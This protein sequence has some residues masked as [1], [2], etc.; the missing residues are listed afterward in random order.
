MDNIKNILFI[1]FEGKFNENNFPNIYNKITFSNINDIYHDT[2]ADILVINTNNL[3][4]NE[5]DIIKLEN[6]PVIL[7]DNYSYI[8]KFI[9]IR[10]NQDFYFIYQDTQ[11]K[12]LDTLEFFINK[13]YDKKKNR[14][15]I[16]E[17]NNNY[18][19][20]LIIE[21]SPLGFII[22]DTEGNITDLNNKLL[23]ILGSPSTQETKKI[24]LLKFEPLKKSGYSDR[25]IECIETKKTIVEEIEY[26]TKWGKTIFIR[27]Y[28]TP[29]IEN[30]N[31]I[32][33]QAILEDITDRRINEIKLIS[34]LK[35]K[36]ILLKEIHHRVKNNLQIISS[37]L[38]LQ[39]VYIEDENTK[40]VLLNIK[41]RIKSMSLVHEKLYI[42]DNLG[43]IKIKNYISALLNNIFTSYLLGNKKINYNFECNE[44][45]SFDI[46]YTINIGLII[47]EIVSNS[48]KHAFD[49]KNTGNINIELREDNNIYQLIIE[50]DGIGISNNF[51]TNDLKTLGVNLIYSFVSQING[52][53]DIESIKGSKF[54]ITFRYENGYY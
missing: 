14:L 12:F 18:K 10:K 34:S 24:N 17:E 30:N 3:D 8:D 50:D 21:N 46:E 26:T 43:K 4:I 32:G 36:E 42:G 29:L 25:F 16:L 9:K 7:I 44:L 33:I 54:I 40:S 48:L 53:I 13:L 51:N 52:K 6:Y 38:N 35:E 5:N 28:M 39:Q 41:N 22:A 23:E 49:N 19:Y 37:L 47:N 20:K 27:Y 15:K 2:Q 45:I 1:N 11:N 31:V